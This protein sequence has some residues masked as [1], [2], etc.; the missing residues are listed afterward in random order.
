MQTNQETVSALERRI[1]MTVPLADIEKDVEARLKQMARTVK[2]PGFRPGKVPFR[3]VAQ[4]YGSQARSEA[5]GAAVERVLAEQIRAQNLRIAGYPRIEPK[6]AASTEALEF[7]AVFEVYPEV[8]VGDLSAREVE[9]PILSVTEAEVDKTLEVLRKQRTTFVPAERAA[10][11]GDRV[12]VDFTGR[13]DGVEFDGGKATDFPFVIGAGQMLKDFE[14][15]VVGLSAGESK[16]FDMTFPDDYHASHLAGQAVQ[17][18]VTVKQVA[19]PKLPEVDGEFAKSLGIADGDTSKMREEVKANLE[20][21]VKRRIQARIKEQVMNV[22]LDA[23][24]IEVPKALVEQESQQLA[25]NARK[26]FESRGMKT[27]DLPISTDWFTDQ[28]VRRVKLG[29][30]MSELVRSKELFAKPEQIRA[31]IEDFAA[32]YEDPSEVVSWYYAQ[33]E[34]LAQAEALV[35]EDNVVAWVVGNAKATDKETSFE[36]LM[37]NAA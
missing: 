9:R 8:V 13:K 30:I 32:S 18:E 16:T 17:F 27:K 19:E 24:P 20:R 36:E 23:H 6:D 28:A 31:I 3:M 35:V 4:S 25:D 10:Q 7:S 22:L 21:E 2:M 37:G 5:V 12:T 29:L 11:D 33:P 15:A 1:D 14:T 34:R 26:D